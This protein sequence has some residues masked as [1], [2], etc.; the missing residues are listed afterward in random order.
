VSINLPAGA[1]TN[2]I[3]RVQARGL[4]NNLPITVVVT[5]DY[6]SAVQY[7]AVIQNTGSPSFIDVNVVLPYDMVTHIHAWTR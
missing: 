5:P 6:G 7:P 1:S 2:Q 4:T 3:V